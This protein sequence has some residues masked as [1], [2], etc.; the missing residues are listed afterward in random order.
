LLARFVSGHAFEACRI[1]LDPHN[2]LR[3]LRLAAKAGPFGGI[4]CKAEAMP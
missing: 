4:H 1:T 2:A 3:A